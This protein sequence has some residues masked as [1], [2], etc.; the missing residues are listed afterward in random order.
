MDGVVQLVALRDAGRRQHVDRLGHLPGIE[1]AVRVAA[2]RR[3]DAELEALRRGLEAARLV[4]AEPVLAREHDREAPAGGRRA[5]GALGDAERDVARD[6]VGPDGD[7]A[8]RRPT[9]VDEL[10]AEALDL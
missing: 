10:L 5:E 4:R 8:E 2:G 1:R 9:R 3:A 7:R 6:V